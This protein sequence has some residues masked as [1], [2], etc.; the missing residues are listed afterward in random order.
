MNMKRPLL[1]HPTIVL[2]LTSVVL[3][4]FA[5]SAFA[6]AVITVAQLNGTVRDSSGSVVANATVSL[7]N[8]DTNRTYMS[9][10]DASGYY[11]VPN[12]PPGSYDLNVTY[13]GFA[14]FMQSSIQLRVGQTATLDV[15]LAVQGVKEVVEVAAETPA[16]EPTR[17]EL[18]NVIETRQIQNLPISGRLFTDFALLTPGVTTGRTSVGST[19]TEF[20]VSRVSFAGMRDLSNQVTV[21]GADNINTATGSQR[22]TPPQEAVQEFRV[23]NN[24]FGAEYGRALGGIVNIVTKTGTNSLHGSIY[25]YFQNNSLNARSLLQPEPQPNVLRQNQFGATLGGPLKKDKTFFFVNYEGQRRGESPTYPT[26]LINNIGLI[27]AS[28]AA[29]G[30]ATENLNILKTKDNDYGFA[31]LDHQLSSRHQLAVRYNIEDGR[32]LNQLVGNTLDG[33]GIGAPSSGHNVFVRDQSLSGTLTSQLGSNIVNTALVQYARRHY[34]FPGVTGEPNLDIPNELLFGHNFGVLDKIWETRIQGSDSMS[35][36]R[37]K[38]FLRFGGDFNHVRNFVLWPGFTPIR[39]IL[40]GIN[41]LV[42]FANFVKP[43]AG[44]LSNFAAGPCPMALPPFSDPN[45]PNPFPPAPGPNPVDIANGVPIAFQSAPLGTAVNF[46]PGVVEK[47]PTNGWPYA[48]LPEQ[49]PNFSV[50]LNHNYYGFFIQ[51]QW[52]VTPKL[53][54]NYGLRYDFESGLSDQM[55]VS[56]KGFQPRVGL[57]YSPDKKTVIRAGFGLFNDRYALSFLF[58]TYPQRP[59]II[60]NA[61]LPPNRRGAESAVYELNQYPFGVP[62]L[63]SPAEIAR[64]FFTTGEVF[65]QSV[66]IPTSVG[67]S[68][69]DRKSPI[70]Y[71]EQA[72]LE[73]NREV[74]RG[75]TIGAGYLF[76]AAHHL[77]R[78]TLGN[79]CPVAGITGGTY[80]CP[81]AGP[82]PPGYPA[83]KNYYSG[84]PRYPAGL[85]C[86]NDLTGNSVYHGGTLQVNQRAGKYGNLNASYTL[87]HTLD[88]GTFATFIS[89]PEDVFRRGL[90]R[91]T[92]NQDARH[93]FVANF[94]LTGPSTSFMRNFT[95]SNI[96]TLQSARPF[97]LFVGFDS[98]NDL[99]PAADRVGNLSRNTYKGDSFQSW[100]FRLARTFNLSRERTRVELALDAF[101]TFNR[102]N[103]DE[104]TGVYGTYNLCGGQQ[105]VQYKDSGSRAIQAGQVGGC[106]LAGPPVPNPLFGTPRTMFSPRQLQ[107]SAKLLF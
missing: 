93:R 91:A 6:Q 19:I 26:V 49:E 21:D 14:P 69:T 70:P 54:M 13:T 39:I 80:P 65:S 17:T 104:V 56:H 15:T 27:N 88:D 10:S 34:T 100:D 46:T 64:T 16:I 99:I 71:S 68:Y 101:N 55:D 77:L 20:E 5:N 29:L 30:I 87:S 66:N 81:P 9:T 57:A 82:P 98:N 48:Y 7:R 12:L 106:P 31:R 74:G 67:Y 43:S 103:V 22:S 32:D 86:C 44:I 89:V 40:P 50:H 3:M 79:L 23:V 85:I 4:L 105:P 62:G 45:F 53:T 51:D 2:L 37:G 61:D 1:A 78:S 107:L 41:C 38:H 94:S 63:P 36:V 28:K 97:T 24:S 52:K 47:L 75:L 95:L 42:D 18:S 11:I 76:V 96:V 102:P 25:D 35:W 72:S 84:I 73:I 8:V 59:A 90:E 33:G 58:I 60:P 83:G 92:S